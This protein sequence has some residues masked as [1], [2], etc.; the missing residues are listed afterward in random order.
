[1]IDQVNPHSCKEVKK[2]RP[3]GLL[4]ELLKPNSS[5]W[6]ILIMNDICREAELLDIC[7]KKMEVV[8]SRQNQLFD[9]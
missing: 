4:P 9:Q 3:A 8:L 2:I 5:F 1:M 7:Q 6:S